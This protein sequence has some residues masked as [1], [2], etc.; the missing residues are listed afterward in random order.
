MPDPQTVGALKPEIA[1]LNQ[2]LLEAIGVS[3]ENKIVT[4]NDC[5]SIHPVYGLLYPTRTGMQL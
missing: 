5:Q 3:G 1:Q 4:Q 2:C